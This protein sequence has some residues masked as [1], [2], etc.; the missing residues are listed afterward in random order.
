M[1][2]DDRCEPPGFRH[3]SMAHYLDLN[4][5][6]TSAVWLQFDKAWVINGSFVSAEMAHKIGYR[7]ISTFR[8]FEA[9]G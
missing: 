3:G 9:R 6:I 4:G 5:A 7:Y 2:E 8:E 1:P